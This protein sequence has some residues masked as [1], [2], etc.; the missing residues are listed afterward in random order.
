VIK[1]ETIQTD[2]LQSVD[3]FQ[4]N[5]ID[6]GQG[7]T[8]YSTEKKPVQKGKY[9]YGFSFDTAISSQDGVYAFLYEKLGTKG[10][11]LKHGSMIREINRSYYHAGV[12]QYPTAFFTH[13]QKTYL[14]HCPNEYNRLEIE[15][16]E[17]GE[18]IQ[19]SK[20]R[21]PEDC[22]HSRLEVSQN[23]KYLLVKG[24][25]WHPWD[26]IGVYDLEACLQDSSLLDKALI[27]SERIPQVNSASFVDKDRVLFH[28]SS[29][30]EEDENLEEYYDILPHHLG[31]WNLKTNAVES[32]AHLK[33]PSGNIFAIDENYAWDLYQHPKII[34]TPTGNLVDEIKE[35]N[36]GEEASSII[37]HLTNL[38]KIAFDTATKKVAIAINNQIEV[39]SFESK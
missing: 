2:Y 31:I 13:N 36:S 6:W 9:Y 38:P 19:S 25:Y 34:H 7:A 17:T 27:I 8:I 39:L 35:I 12:Y 26:G 21:N 18:M 1:R 10:I 4:G 16:V 37:H 22:F 14:I 28:T 24:W 23:Q 11:L 3:W 20:K 32:S 30:D 15:D 33:F 5:I 29:E